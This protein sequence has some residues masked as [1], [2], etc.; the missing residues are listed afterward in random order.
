MQIRSLGVDNDVERYLA[1]GTT[2]T[3]TR[4]QKWETHCD[5][6]PCALHATRTTKTKPNMHKR[7]NTLY[8]QTLVN[9][10]HIIRL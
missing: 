9:D 3:G 6:I 7:T 1:H 8:G 10:L 2:R 4:T 5:Q